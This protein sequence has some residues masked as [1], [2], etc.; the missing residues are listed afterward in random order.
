MSSLAAVDPAL[1][2]ELRRAFTDDVLLTRYLD[3]AA[4]SHDASQYLLHPQAVV[5]ARSFDD[6]ATAFRASRRSRTPITFRSGG[7]SLS[8]QSVGDGILID[9][10]R[11][12]RGIEVLDDGLRVRCGPGA[13]IRAVNLRLAR[14]GRKIG[15]DPASDSACTIGGVIANNSSGMACGTEQN[16]Y[17]TIESLT[18]VLPSGTVL[19]TDA[20][21][22]DEQFRQNEP[23]LYDTI[24]RLRERVRENPDSLARIAEQYRLKN[25]MGY[26]VNSFV[27]HDD[28][29][30]ILLH[31]MVGSEGTLGF[32][33][34][35]VLRTVPLLP[36]AATALAL[37]P[38]II[39]ATDSLPGLRAAGARVLELLDTASLGVA[40]RFPGGPE[41]LAGIDLDRH[42]AVLI[43]VQEAENG[44]RD[45][46]RRSLEEVLAGAATSAPTRFTSSSRERAALWKTRKGLYPALAAAR[47]SGR[48][49]LLEDV[50]VPPEHL[51]TA[52]EE[53]SRLLTGT[54][55]DDAVIFGHAK[56]GN[57]H[58]LM[59]ADLG[60]SADIARYERFT[61]ELVDLV[62][63][64]GGTLKAEHGTGRVMAPFVE[65][66]FGPELYAVM[67]ELRSAIDPDHLLGRGVLISD[68]PLEHLK[69]L[70]STPDVGGAADR[71]VECGF[72]EPVCPSRDLTTTPRQRIVLLREMRV[73]GPRVRKELARDFE[74]AAVQTCA[75]DSMCLTACPVEIDTGAL[76]K[77]QRIESHG[78]LAER[79]ALVIARH[80]AG[81]E[82]MARLALRIAPVIP[83]WLI[84]GALRP[85][86]A[87]G[88]SDLVPMPG[89]ELPGAGRRRSS[90]RDG[91]ERKS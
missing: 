11:N 25:T 39:D 13:T 53:L 64:R 12:F 22:A 75:A 74:Y 69:N 83:R 72:C 78:P 73:A 19:R 86:R 58:F 16:S 38:S 27:D 54:G 71:C 63:S 51:S 82:A 3:R 47:P 55:Y 7:T 4:M 17:R 23:G 89:P 91:G 24:L 15:P 67:R 6:I 28:P 1:E 42:A 46:V 35:V 81:V 87:L 44:E 29:I 34:D 48:A 31:L 68:D 9:S 43:E 10:R 49:T 57:L 79:I 41:D 90:A 33:G 26:G 52:V 40:Q 32:I 84:R 21:D 18:M 66:Q 85:I 8:G 80:W 65:R 2:A 77:Q 56:D 37:F 14:F 76:M 5:R 59:T 45:T 62:L 36:S 60:D 50:A 88:L 61:M 20:P 30:D 70:K